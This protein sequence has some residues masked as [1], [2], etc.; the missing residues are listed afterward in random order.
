MKCQLMF[1]SFYH[2][3]IVKNDVIN[4][5]NIGLMTSQSIQSDIK[6]TPKNFNLIK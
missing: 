2:M 1:H 3:I 6:G 5:F 4:G